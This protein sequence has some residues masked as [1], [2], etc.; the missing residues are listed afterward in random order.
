MKN[1][2]LMKIMTFLEK[3]KVIPIEHREVYLYGLEL[4]LEKILHLVMIIVISAIYARLLEGMI[5]VFLYSGLRKSAGGYHAKTSEGCILFTVLIVNLVM[6]LVCSNKLMF[7]NGLDLSILGG[8]LIYFLAPMDCENKPIDQHSIRKIRKKV[9]ITLS[10][11]IIVFTIIGKIN[12]ECV[13]IV[14]ITIG[15]Q[16]MVMVLGMKH[17]PRYMR[18]FKTLN[19]KG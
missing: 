10:I 6:F 16:V 13:K 19:R 5:F 9:L 1:I 4:Y 7:K 11:F 17:S 12:Y 15:I 18:I 8:I 3:Y 2:F 14:P